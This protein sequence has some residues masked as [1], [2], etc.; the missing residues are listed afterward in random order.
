MSSLSNPTTTFKLNQGTFNQD[1]KEMALEKLCV[2]VLKNRSDA[3]GIAEFISFLL[4]DSEISN[5]ELAKIFN[6][7]AVHLFSKGN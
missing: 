5:L 1:V 6:H 2:Y 7:A 3:K 4:E